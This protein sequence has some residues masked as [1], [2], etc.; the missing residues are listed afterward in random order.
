M[1]SKRPRENEPDAPQPKKPRIAFK[2]GPDNLPD[3]TWKRKVIKIKRN[4]IHK[5]K[6]KKSYAKLKAREAPVD[7]PIP[8]EAIEDGQAAAQLPPQP[9]LELHPDDHTGNNHENPHILK[10]RLLLQSRRKLKR[11]RGG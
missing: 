4:L 1:A 5:A 2:V 11:R 10:S 6:I 8:D 9:S 3:G 7:K